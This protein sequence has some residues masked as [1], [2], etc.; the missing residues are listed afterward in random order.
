VILWTPLATNTAN[1]SG[2]FQFSDPNTAVHPQRFYR[3]KGQ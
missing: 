1:T 2:V 3:I